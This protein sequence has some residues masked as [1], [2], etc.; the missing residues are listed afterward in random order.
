MLTIRPTKMLAKKL[1]IILPDSPPPVASRLADWCVHEFSF[2]RQRWLMFCNTASLYPV[3]AKG[4]GVVD[5]ETLGRRLGGMLGEVLK[6]NGSPSQWA[7]IEPQ[8]HEAQWAP[9]PGR[10][11]LGVINEMIFLACA[12]LEDK[13]MTP[14]K[15]AHR[16]AKTP[17]TTLGMNSPD[18]VFPTLSR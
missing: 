11:V 10:S 9:I 15:L 2:E 18:R 12:H 6:E 8:L 7:L 17:L 14:A 4:R 13:S 3:V 16:L 5:G 1:G